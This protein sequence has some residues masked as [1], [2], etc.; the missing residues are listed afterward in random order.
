MAFCTNCGM[1]LA[2]GAR[3]CSGCGA[4][5]ATAPGPAAAQPAL[6]P[7]VEYT[8]QG[9]NLQVLRMKLVRGQEVYAEAGKAIIQT[10]TLAKLR[11]ELGV[12]RGGGEEHH[13]LPGL[14][15]ILGSED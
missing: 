3:F 12:L 6:A 9:D 1:E 2:A 10:M 13:G 4:S 7:P 14:G 8:I 11:R 5:Q 15:S